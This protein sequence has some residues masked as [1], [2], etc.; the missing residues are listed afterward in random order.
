MRQSELGRYY[1]SPLFLLPAL[2]SLSLLSR[3]SP[4]INSAP[5]RHSLVTHTDTLQSFLL[6]R[7]QLPKIHSEMVQTIER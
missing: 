5:V 4:S 7:K 3:S 2:F 6:K 1:F